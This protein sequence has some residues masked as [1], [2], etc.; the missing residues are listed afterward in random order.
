MKCVRL[1]PIKQL[2]SHEK[3]SAKKVDLVL[4]DL[5][6]NRCIKNPLVA[7]RKTLVVLDGHHRVN[8]LKKLGAS[9]APVFLVDYMKES[10]KV[11]LR[12]KNLHMSMIKHAVI[13]NA[14]RNHLFPIKTTR[15]V[16]KN[17]PRNINVG[18]NRLH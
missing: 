2:K 10:V 18:L 7:D 16:I 6:R 5:L 8:A 1:I 13:G 17:R 3:I 9:K 11:Y 14:L 12:R 4:N 15:H